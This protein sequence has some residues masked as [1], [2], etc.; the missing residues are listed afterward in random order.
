MP[1]IEGFMPYLGFKTYFRIV[2]K[3]NEAKAPL[4]VLHGGPGGSHNTLEV[5]DV[6]SLAEGRQI[7]YYDQ[8]GCG[9]SYVEG[10]T[11]L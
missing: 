10:H 8:L 2:G 11:D 3:G 9:K 7:I 6:L 1:V 5:L 4:V